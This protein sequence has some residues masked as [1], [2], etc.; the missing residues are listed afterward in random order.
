MTH[1]IMTERNQ[2][3]LATAELYEWL[4]SAPRGQR[5]V[6]I[7]QP[8]GGDLTAVEGHV[9]YHMRQA[10]AANR[11]ELFTEPRGKGDKRHRAH[12]LEKL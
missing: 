9:A 5:R 8:L 1:E 2:K 6:F 7:R 12:I 3:T 11:A 10:A 4:G